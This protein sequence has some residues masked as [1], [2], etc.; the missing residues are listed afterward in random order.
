MPGTSPDS[1]FGRS[2]GIVVFALAI[3]LLALYRRTDLTV[4]YGYDGDAFLL[5][6]FVAAVAVVV[7]AWRYRDALPPR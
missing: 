6:F 5:G 2:I 3:G 1:T 4:P 7:V